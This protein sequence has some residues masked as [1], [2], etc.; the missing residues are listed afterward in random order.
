VPSAQETG[1]AEGAGRR[2][3]QGQ[4][5][6]RSPASP[7]FGDHDIGPHRGCP[8]SSPFAALGR[9]RKRLAAKID[10]GSKTLWAGNR[11]F[12]NGWRCLRSLGFVGTLALK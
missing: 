7:Q 11:R 1:Y 3:F 9:R 4:R 2:Y 8:L 10:I 12:L 6:D 5:E